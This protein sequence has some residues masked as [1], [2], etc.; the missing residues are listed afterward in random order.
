[1][2]VVTWFNKSVK[3]FDIDQ[4][5]HSIL[6]QTEGPFFSSVYYL[7]LTYEFLCFSTSVFCFLVFYLYLY[8]YILYI[9]FWT[10]SR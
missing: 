9:F 6:L 3:S 1:M 7:Q 5:V 8:V 4:S 2:M 10:I